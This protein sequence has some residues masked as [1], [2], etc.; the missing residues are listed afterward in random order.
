MSFYSTASTK[1]VFSFSSINQSSMYLNIDLLQVVFTA[2]RTGSTTADIS[3]EGGMSTTFSMVVVALAFLPTCLLQ[4]LTLVSFLSMGGLIATLATITLVLHKAFGELEDD[5][6]GFIPDSKHLVGNARHLAEDVREGLFGAL[7]A[8]A[9]SQTEPVGSKP[10]LPLSLL[11]YQVCI[12][13]TM[14]VDYDVEY[15]FYI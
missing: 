6:D 15:N 3:G 13:R 14:C 7:M 1:C 11:L 10:F 5:V 4:D 8:R 2:V 12:T 9:E